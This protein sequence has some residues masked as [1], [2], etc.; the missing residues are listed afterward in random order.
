[1]PS[2]VDNIESM[3]QDLAARP[4]RIAAHSDM[5]FA[6]FVYPPGQEFALRKQL[7]LLSI[8][9]DQQHGRH[10]TFVSLARL[11]WDVV[12]EHEGSG[13]LFKTET[14]RGFNAAQRHVN[15]LLSSSDFR[16][17]V[18][19]LIGNIERLDPERDVVFL[20][21]TGGFAP[22]IYRAS[23]LLDGLHHKTMVPVVLYYPGSA[24]VGTDLRFFD[25]PTEGNLGAYNYRVRIYGAEG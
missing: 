3:K 14:L 4:M 22:G 20:V 6:I 10:V 15:H 24:R 18:D 2:L 1:M 16:P 21:R 8:T 13:Y 23:V 17:A 9:L 25:M 5:P 19:A 7:R 12:R 11:V